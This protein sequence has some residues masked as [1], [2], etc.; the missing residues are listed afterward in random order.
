MPA[1]RVTRA[2]AVALCV[3][4]LSLGVR[5]PTAHAQDERPAPPASEALFRRML[6]ER[7]EYASTPGRATTMTIHEF[8]V[9]KPV[10]WTTEY[11]ADDAQDKNTLVYKV[12][13]RYTVQAENVNTVTGQ[14]HAATSR[15][16]RRQYNYYVNR[17]GRWV[18]RMGPTTA[19]WK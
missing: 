19:D 14:R 16:Y 1:L 15:E 13:A 12:R 18:A 17:D 8:H 11:G 2:A 4:H 6:Q 7:P 9:A 10:R 3:V 5:S